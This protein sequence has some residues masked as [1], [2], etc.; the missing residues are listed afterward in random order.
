MQNGSDMQRKTKNPPNWYVITG[1]PSSGK[2]TLLTRLEKLG[3]RVMYEVA[4]TYIDEEM[5]K[6]RTLSDIRRDE[7]TFQKEV[8]RRK[9]RLEKELDPKTLCFFE[10]GIPDSIAY[11]EIAGGKPDALLKKSLGDSKYKRVFLLELISF[12]RDYARTEDAKIAQKIAILLE[13]SYKD[14]GHPV[15]KVPKLNTEDRVKIILK[16]I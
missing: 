13:K 3:Y 5:K 9:I 11:Y 14:A 4:R 8:L 2:T 12:R 1:A 10:R 6:G 7:L 15:T 16:Y